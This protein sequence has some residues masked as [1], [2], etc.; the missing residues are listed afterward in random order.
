M[1]LFSTTKRHDFSEILTKYLLKFHS[2]KFRDGGPICVFYRQGGF[3]FAIKTRQNAVT[4]A[5]YLPGFR[6]NQ[7][8]DHLETF[9]SKLI[10]CRL[11]MDIIMNFNGTFEI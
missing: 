11:A 9:H 10:N 4:N 8:L 6:A 3:F 2:F 7:S 5:F 1:P